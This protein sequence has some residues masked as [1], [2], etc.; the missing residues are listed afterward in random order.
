V[1][2]QKLRT[3]IDHISGDLVYVIRE[4]GERGAVENELEADDFEVLLSRKE[5]KDLVV[6]ELYETYFLPERHESDWQV[7]RELLTIVTNEHVRQFVATSV[8][9]GVVGSTAFE[10]LRAA[11]GRILSEMRKAKLPSSR[12]QPFRAMKE[13]VNAVEAFF[14]ESECARMTEIE[15]S[16]GI[17]QGRLHPLLKLLGFKHYRREHACHWCRPGTAEVKRA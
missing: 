3:L 12:R 7:L 8:V 5:F 16:T 2:E 14:G 9:G 1:D 11:L 4:V 15:S 6:G 13:D 10:V 17:P